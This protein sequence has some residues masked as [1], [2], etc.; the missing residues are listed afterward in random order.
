MRY[1]ATKSNCVRNT[2]L[3]TISNNYCARI[4][5]LNDANGSIPTHVST[6][7]RCTPVNYVKRKP[8]AAKEATVDNSLSIVRS[9]SREA[10]RTS[11][12]KVLSIPSHCPRNRNT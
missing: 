2:P 6:G 4:I 11:T 1:S 5:P 7:S 12:T 9:T 10:E 8:V 3:L